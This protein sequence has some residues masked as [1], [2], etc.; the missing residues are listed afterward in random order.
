MFNVSQCTR[1]VVNNERKSV[2]HSFHLNVQPSQMFDDSMG[3]N[4][5]SVVN[6]GCLSIIFV[7]DLKMKH[8]FHPIITKLAQSVGG[9]FVSHSDPW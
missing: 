7:G 5:P 9:N 6:A 8:V 4:M 1:S 2:A 3:K